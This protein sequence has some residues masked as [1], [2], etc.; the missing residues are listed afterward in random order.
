[1]LLGFALAAFNP[2]T[3]FANTDNKYPASDFQPSVIY[4]DK[5]AVTEAAVAEE[6][7]DPKY[8][9]ANFQPKVVYIDNNLAKQ[10]QVEEE[11]D[12]A[13]PKYPAAYFKPKVIYP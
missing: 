7:A 13:D 3:S 6:A 5:S 10:D 11:Q 2:L 1:M 9:A 4:I 8:P 12:Q